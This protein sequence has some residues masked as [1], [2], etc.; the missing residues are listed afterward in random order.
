MSEAP[1]RDETR[2][3]RYSYLSEAYFTPAVGFQFY[4]VRAI[5]MSAGHQLVTSHALTA[6]PPSRFQTAHD[7]WGNEVCYGGYNA[8]HDHF[9]LLSEGTVCCSEYRWFEAH[10]SPLYAAAGP[11]TTPDAG[12]RE[13]IRQWQEEFCVSPDGAIPSIDTLWQRRR[14]AV[15][16]MHHAHRLLSY[17]RG[18]TDCSTTAA[19]A[20]SL[21][22]GVC[23]DYA[24]VMI[25]LCRLVGLMARYACGLIV[26]EG[27]THAWVE[28]Y[29]GLVWY[30]Y[31]PTYDRQ[32][33]WDYLKIA[34]GRDA[35]D[36]PLNRG[37][38]YQCTSERLYVSAKV[39][40]I[41]GE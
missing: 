3:Y 35:A 16:L 5:P 33:Q 27:E 7:V 9:F 4:K 1:F 2:T 6:F 34:H 13:A 24:H 15:S 23:Q 31:D 22:R 17:Q 19:Q 29:D 41:E 40:V 26:G 10:P 12:L 30:G 32:I 39:S 21:G 14:V 25:A 37:L 20:L 36:C 38:L 11:L 8:P 28:V 18:V